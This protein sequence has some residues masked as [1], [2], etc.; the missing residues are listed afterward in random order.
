MGDRNCFFNAI[1]AQVQFDSENCRKRFGPVHLHRQ[2][3]LHYIKGMDLSENIMVR[4]LKEN[5]DLRDREEQEDGPFYIHD[6]LMFMS[7]DKAWAYSI[8]IQLLA[9]MCG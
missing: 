6:Y 8:I 3:L 5:Y 9:S 2:I 4:G 1:L 7:E